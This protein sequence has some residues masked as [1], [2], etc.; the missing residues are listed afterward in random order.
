MP[1]DGSGN[2]TL[3]SGYEA[4]TG[5]DILPSNH[6]PPLEDIESA[7]TERVM[8]DGRKAMT[9]NLNMGSNRIINVTTPSGGND[10]ANKAY[11][12]T[13]IAAIEVGP[14]DIDFAATKR[15]LGRNTADAGAGEEVTAAQFMNWI[16][17]PAQGDVLYQG[18]S[19]IARLAAGTAGQH[20]V[21]NGAGANPAWKSGGW[22]LLATLTASDSATLSDT[23]SLTS[24]YSE[25]EIEFA[26]V[27]PA[28]A[29]QGLILQVNSG[30]VQNSSYVSHANAFGGNSATP[31]SGLLTSGV[32]IGTQATYV[33][34]NT[35]TTGL[36]GF[37]RIRN[38]ASTSVVKMVFG[39]IAGITAG[40]IVYASNFSGFWNG[41]TGAIT[42]FQVAF[43]SGNIASGTVKIYGRL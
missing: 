2:Y 35:G 5:E 10:A 36:N 34:T 12:D 8:A 1:T 11:V 29:S 37:C 26:N 31:I 3:P 14:T 43:A 40:G 9:G 24:A 30:G 16:G 32:P 25:Y 15:V 28:T 7:L 19:D 39:Q 20:L 21:T 6:N 38:P 42:G 41:G 13:A 4:V 17:T 22:T 33:P 27:L 18:A 23:T